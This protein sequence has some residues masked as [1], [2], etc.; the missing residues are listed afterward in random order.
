M[1]NALFKDAPRELDAWRHVVELAISRNV[2]LVPVVLEAE[3]D[4]I[5]GVFRV[6]TVLGKK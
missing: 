2:P 4:E 1:T 6:P 5:S 3:L